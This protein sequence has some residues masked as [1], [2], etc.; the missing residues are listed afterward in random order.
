MKQSEN[1]FHVTDNSI[2]KFLKNYT[3]T[4]KHGHEKQ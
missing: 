2:N 4:M 3:S 1:V